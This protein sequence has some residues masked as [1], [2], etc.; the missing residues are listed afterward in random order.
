MKQL[1]KMIQDDGGVVYDIRLATLIEECGSTTI[2]ELEDVFHRIHIQNF[3][4]VKHD[5][6]TLLSLVTHCRFLKNVFIQQLWLDQEVLKEASEAS[7]SNSSICFEVSY[8][9]YIHA[10]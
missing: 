10:W 1:K 5:Q 6:I 2:A 8:V 4:L 3:D 7:R 9:M